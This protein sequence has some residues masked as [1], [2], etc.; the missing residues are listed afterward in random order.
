MSRD[1]NGKYRIV[2]T[3]SKTVMFKTLKCLVRAV[4]G[5]PKTQWIALFSIDLDL[6]AEQNRSHQHYDARWKIGSKFKDVKK[7]RDSSK[8][9]AR[10]AHAVINHISFSMM[11]ATIT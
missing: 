1:Y 3:F 2:N 11:A 7:D 9:Q 10:N 5:F 6:S 8:S 4:C